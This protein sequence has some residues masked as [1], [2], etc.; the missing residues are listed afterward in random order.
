V[1]LTIL[2]LGLKGR[3]AELATAQQNTAPGGAGSAQPA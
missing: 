3:A 1:L 2:A